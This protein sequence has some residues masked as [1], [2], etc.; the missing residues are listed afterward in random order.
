MT[1]VIHQMC[2]FKLD[3]LL[4]LSTII[5]KG[6]IGSPRTIS[7]KLYSNCEKQFSTR[8]IFMPF[9]LVAMNHS[10]GVGEISTQPSG[11]IQLPVSPSLSLEDMG[12]QGSLGV[13]VLTRMSMCAT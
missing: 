9:F 3:V 7:A 4:V 5:Y 2:N 10:C 8:R 13:S 12:D 6:I 11:Q 1:C